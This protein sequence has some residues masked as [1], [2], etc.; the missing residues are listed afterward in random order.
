M[1]SFKHIQNRRLKMAE[2]AQLQMDA[3]FPDVPSEYLWQRKKNDGFSTVPRTLPIAMQAIDNQT[4]GTP[5]GHTLFC[6]WARSPDH[7][8]ITIENPATFA[9]EAGFTGERAVHTWRKKMKRLS[10]LRFI[11]PS[12]GPSGDYHY[13]L[14]INPNVA[15]EWMRCDNLVQDELYARFM[16]RVADI[17]AYSDLEKIRDL[18]AKQRATQEAAKA[19]EV[20]A[21][22]TPE[23]NDGQTSEAGNESATS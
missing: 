5:A 16:S 22:P 6:L 12:K 21:P 19:S 3:L 7:P 13:V 11:L 23:E 20:P 4:K 15:V 10:E 1:T 9:F 8:L 17:G 14:L 18:W 2:R